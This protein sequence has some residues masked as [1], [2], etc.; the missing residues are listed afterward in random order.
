MSTI[1]DFTP[2]IRE[3]HP[4]PC[5]KC[6]SA[7]YIE[8]SGKHIKWSCVICGYIKF[9]QQHWTLRIFPV[10]KNKGQK[11]IDVCK[12]DPEYCQWALKNMDIKSV[13]EALEQAIKEGYL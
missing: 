9:L 11:I 2:G 12:I 8:R 7:T 4:H 6:G 3:S 13:R 1:E 10:G 5:P